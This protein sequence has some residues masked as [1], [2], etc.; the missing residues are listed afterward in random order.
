M[1]SD[2]VIPSPICGGGKNFVRPSQEKFVARPSKEIE[3]VI[4]GE[5]SAQRRAQS[6]Q[7]APPSPVLCYRH[8]QRNLWTQNCPV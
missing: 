5:T 8:P 3:A 2:G 6:A 4:R 7:F 1:K